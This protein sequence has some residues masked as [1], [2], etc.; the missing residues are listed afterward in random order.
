LPYDF[1][2]DLE[3]GVRALCVIVKALAV[4]IVSAIVVFDSDWSRSHVSA[5]CHRTIGLDVKFYN[6]FA[7]E[8]HLRCC[9]FRRLNPASVFFAFVRFA[10]NGLRYEG[11]I[12]L[13]FE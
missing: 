10:A 4:E 2:S 11:L 9:L 6:P 3:F 13:A 5:I 7:K 1:S 8:K 12:R